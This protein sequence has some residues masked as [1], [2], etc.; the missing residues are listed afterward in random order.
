MSKEKTRIFGV[1]NGISG[2]GKSYF[3]KNYLIPELVKHKPV[4]ILD[5]TGEYS[6]LPGAAVYQNFPEF[7]QRLTDGGGKLQRRPHVFLWNKNQTAIDLIRFVRFIEKPVGLVLEEAHVLF[8]DSDLSKKI[9]TPLQ[10]VT[11]LGRHYEIDSI[12]CTQTP[13]CLPKN[14]RTQAQFFVSFRQNEPADLEYL[15]KKDPAAPDVVKNLSEKEFYSIGFK[16]VED[17]LS[18]IKIN[19]VNQ[20]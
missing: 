12:L 3:L 2:F 18:Q 4:L 1:V 8:N 11:F 7:L 5:I 14:V 19:K 10:E 6:E 9:K 20:L 13:F 17:K 15:R 16:S